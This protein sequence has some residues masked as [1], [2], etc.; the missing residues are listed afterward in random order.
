MIRFLKPFAFCLIILILSSC[1]ESQNN[2]SKAESWQTLFDGKSLNGWVP[3]IHRH[4]VGD[5]F[6][7]TFRVVDGVIQV[8]MINMR[9]LKKSTGISFTKNHFLLFTSNGNI[10]LRTNGCPMHQASPTVIAVSCF[11]LKTPK[12]SSRSRIGLYR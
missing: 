3:K 7:E 9:S 2:E 5:N 11:T 1:G 10:G 12:P 8:N 6:G 4:E